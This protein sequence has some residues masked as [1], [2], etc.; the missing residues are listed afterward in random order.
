MQAGQ[1]RRRIHGFDPARE[2]RFVGNRNRDHHT[3]VAVVYAD[4][5]LAGRISRIVGTVALHL[6]CDD[7]SRRIDV[8]SSMG[9]TNQEKCEGARDGH[10]PAQGYHPALKSIGTIS[11][12]LFAQS[13]PSS[14]QPY[15]ISIS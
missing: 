7:R 2:D 6:Q 10:R 13:N 3:A 4:I 15:R 12:S 1:S 5:D 8:L 11:S 14:R 9:K